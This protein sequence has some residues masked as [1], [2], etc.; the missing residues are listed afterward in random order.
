ML[1]EAP[2]AQVPGVA[3]AGRAKLDVFV[4]LTMPSK[5]NRIRTMNE[6]PACAH[7]LINTLQPLPRDRIRLQVIQ[8][9]PLVPPGT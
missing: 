2:E 5:Q 6:A 4:V 8:W 9:Q 3:G 7:A 1:D